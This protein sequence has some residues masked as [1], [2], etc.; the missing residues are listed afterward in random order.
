MNLAENFTWILKETNISVGVNTFFF[1][2][3]TK[4][5]TYIICTTNEAILCQF[6][7]S[8]IFYF[9]ASDKQTHMFFLWWMLLYIAKRLSFLFFHILCRTILQTEHICPQFSL[10][11]KTQSLS[12]ST[13]Y[14]NYL[15]FFQTQLR[16]LTHDIFIAD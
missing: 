10:T 14:G 7:L 15:V 5:H 4:L 2:L 6:Q 12:A 9:I 16:T 8:A 13:Y 1:L 11:S 3:T